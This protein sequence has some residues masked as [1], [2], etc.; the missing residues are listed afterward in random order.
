MIRISRGRYF[1][2]LY[3]RHLPRLALCLL[4]L[5]AVSAGCATSPEI[6]AAAHGNTRDLRLLTD[7]VIPKLPPEMQAEWTEN[8]ITFVVRSQVIE[9]HLK[10][11]RFD[12][13]ASEKAE[14]ERVLAARTPATPATPPE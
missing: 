9:A 13:A 2:F 14:T 8:C 6:L 3:L 4:V 11:E 12:Q 1:Q 7:T 5:V 10:G